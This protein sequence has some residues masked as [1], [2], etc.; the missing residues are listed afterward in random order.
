MRLCGSSR[1]KT[2]CKRPSEK[3]HH[4]ITLRFISSRFCRITYTCSLPYRAA[5]MTVKQCTCSKDV[6][7]ISFLGTRKILGFVTRK[8]ISGLPVAVPLPWVITIWTKLLVTLRIR[9]N[10]T[11]WHRK[12][13][14]LG[15][16][17]EVISNSC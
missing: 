7:H 10:T 5:Q 6:H 15:C 8:G 12:P 13:H 11:D 4:H 17:E 3:L 9:N 16:W 2:L 1:I 14:P